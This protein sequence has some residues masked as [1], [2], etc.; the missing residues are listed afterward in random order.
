MSAPALEFTVTLATEAATVFA[1]LTEARLLSRWFCDACESE[2]R[3]NGRLVMRWTR[4]GSS[5]EPF[6]ARWVQFE[7]GTRAAFQGGHAGYPGGNAGTVWFELAAHEGGTRLTVTHTLPA[8][9]G[10]EPMIDAWQRAW[11]RALERLAQAL[12]PAERGA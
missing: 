1:A 11:P 4:A 8:S 10:Y 2:P 7:P 12:A 9:D 3:V 5:R 6:E